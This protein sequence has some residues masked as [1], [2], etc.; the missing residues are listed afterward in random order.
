MTNQN[1]LLFIPIKQRFTPTP[2]QIPCQTPDFR[3]FSQIFIPFFF[4]SFIM[5][6]PCVASGSKWL[7][8]FGKCFLLVF[9]LLF[10]GFQTYAQCPNPVVVRATQATAEGNIALTVSGGVPFEARNTRSTFYKYRW[11]DK[12]GKLFSVQKNISGLVPGTY[13]VAISDNSGCKTVNTYTLKGIPKL[14]FSAERL[15]F[16]DTRLAG[17]SS[18]SFSIT[19]PGNANLEVSKI[20]LPDGFSPDWRS[21]TIAP[22]K[23]Q[24]VKVSFKPTDTKVYTGFIEVISN[25]G[26]SKNTLKVS[27]RGILVTGTEEPVFA[28]LR[29]FPNPADELLHIEL[30]VGMPAADIQLADNQGRLLYQQ[31]GAKGPRLSINLSGYASNIYTLVLQSSGRQKIRLVRKVIIKK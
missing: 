10:L 29:V 16:L 6:S 21:G 25:A 11:T 3:Y 2:P 30:P 19:N 24:V 20:T 18:L 26:S 5:L 1:K 28:D 23:T 14:S 13:T 15:Y 31:Q 12:A 22:G 4:L 8:W 17:T 7:R 9:P 27:G